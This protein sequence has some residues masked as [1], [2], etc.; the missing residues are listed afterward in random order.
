MLD[1]LG[2]FVVL[3]LGIGV[4]YAGLG[5]SLLVT[6][7]GANVVNF[8]IGAVAMWGGYVYYG[9]R[10]VGRLYLP[11]VGIPSSI[12]LGGPVPL[13]VAV[14]GG[15]ASAAV[16][17]LVA[18]VVI[19]RPLRRAPDLAK[20]VASVGLMLLVQ[21]VAAVTFGSQQ[22]VAPSILPSTSLALGGR[23]APWSDVMLLGIIVVVTGVLG[24]YFRFA[25]TGLAMQALAEQETSVA[26]VGRSPSRLAAGAWALSGGLA[27]LFGV[28]VAPL[29][30][31]NTVS[32]TLYVVPALA[33]VLVGR[34]RSLTVTCAAGVALGVFQSV[35]DFLK[36]MSW[37]PGWAQSGVD[38]ALPLAVIVAVLALFG[39]RLPTRND[40]AAVDLPAVAR[41]H[42]PW[43]TLGALG[44]AAAVALFALSGIY[45]FGVIES[46]IG[47]IVM[48]SFVV[49]TGYAGQI[50]LAQLAIAGA[51]G[52]FVAKLTTAAGVPFPVAPLLA[53]MA[54]AACGLVVAV[55][56]LRIRGMQLAIVTLAFAVTVEQ[57]L[58]ANSAFAPPDGLSVQPPRL[59]GMDLAVR[60]GDDVARSSFGVL[61]VVTFV[62]VAGAVLLLARSRSGLRLLAVRANEQAAASVGIGV[63]GAKLGAYALASFVAGLGGALLTYSTGQFSASSFDA[64]AAGLPFLAFAYLGGITSITGGAIAG[65]LA[66]AGILY[67]VLNRYVNNLGPYYLVVSGAALVV[68]A[69]AYPSGMTGTVRELLARRRPSHALVP[70]GAGAPRL[71]DPPVADAVEPPT[72][73]P[74]RWEERPQAGASAEAR[75][76]VRRPLAPSSPSPLGAPGLPGAPRAEPGTVA[77]SVRDLRIAYGTTVV[78]DNVSFALFSGEVTALIGPNGAGKTSI[79]DALT[80]FVE[81]RGSVRLGGEEVLGTAPAK[82]VRRGLVRTWQA[83]TTFGDLSV[84]EDLTVAARRPRRRGSAHGIFRAPGDDGDPVERAL[85]L[86]DLREVADRPTASLSLGQQKLV[87]VGRA[88]ATGPSVLLLDEPAAGLDDGESRLLGRRLREIADEGVAVFLVEHDMDLVFGVSHQVLVLHMGGLIAAGDAASVQTDAGVR[89]AYLGHAA[90]EPPNGC[91]ATPAV[92][93]G[94]GGR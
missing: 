76:P 58:F 84:V 29:V 70:A 57:L 6:Y 55:P 51:G 72:P 85:D 19:F 38:E 22:L 14:I 7:R 28:L 30:G 80:G 89:R 25:R 46:V 27:G 36:T 88:L 40:V 9:L 48:L 4:V 92:V 26:L 56:A 94:S 64:L 87:A 90:G 65:V 50:S 33:V 5:L 24:A 32:D 83:P 11:V 52:V 47:A 10:S 68:A 20:I 93:H 16:L 66:P 62:I 1:E 86:L 18:E 44:G 74:A 53:A 21:S 41:P 45:R 31:L 78:V 81:A 73:P 54:A 71:G 13:W 12:S 17:N 39:N 69:I 3:G 35:I 2:V 59:F 23:S 63:T 49:L 67:V 61:V 75:S 37:Y 34:M 8:A 82:L 42:H 15:V 43:W 77:L 60:A 91:Q 79:L